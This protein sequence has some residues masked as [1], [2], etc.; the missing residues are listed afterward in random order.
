MFGHHPGFDIN[1]QHV[2]DLHWR[3]SSAKY[4]LAPAGWGWG[5]YVKLAVTHGCVPVI[6]QVGCCWAAGAG[7]GAGAACCR[8]WLL[9]W[10]EG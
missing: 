3:L 5:T 8:G 7:A 1:H 10:D 6:V 9:Q 2:Q 4:C